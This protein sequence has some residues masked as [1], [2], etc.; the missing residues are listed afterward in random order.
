M[1]KVYESRFTVENLE[2]LEAALAGGERRVKYSDKEVEYRSFEE[3]VKI[4]DLMMKKLGLLSTCGAK[5][6]FG[7]RRIKAQHS[8]GLDDC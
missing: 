3:M 2:A 6:L 5:G 7:G 4:R 1:A 8:K